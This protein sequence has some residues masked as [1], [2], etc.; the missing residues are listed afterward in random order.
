[1]SKFQNQIDFYDSIC[2]MIENNY[3]LHKTVKIEGAVHCCCHCL[4]C[5]SKLTNEIL[6]PGTLMKMVTCYNSQ[7]PLTKN[8]RPKEEDIDI[9]FPEI[10]C[11]GKEN[12]FPR[13]V[14]D[15]DLIKGEYDLENMVFLFLEYKNCFSTRDAVRVLVIPHVN[16]KVRPY[17][18][19][20]RT[21]GEK[22]V[23]N[24]I[25]LERKFVRTIESL[26]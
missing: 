13:D 3:K 24:D 7:L 9:E 23:G 5:E 15:D 20:T 17:D 26:T 11:G 22:F 12:P 21:W 18:I 1:M 16:L 2:E 6:I 14:P 8:Y 25:C 10:L 4:K 19:D